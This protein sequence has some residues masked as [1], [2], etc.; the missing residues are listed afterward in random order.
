M[1]FIGKKRKDFQQYNVPRINEV[2]A[3]Y[4]SGSDG[5]VPEVNVAVFPKKG[6][7]IKILKSI[8]ENVDP[9][10]YPIFFP[11]GTMGWCPNLK[12]TCGKA[13]ISRAQYVSYRIARRD[14]N[15]AE[16]NPIHY[17]RK[18]FHQYLVDQAIRIEKDRICADKYNNV[19]KSMERRSL[20]NDNT[21]LGKKVFLPSSVTKTPRWQSE[22]YQD[23]M[24]M[25]ARLGK[26]D[27]FLTMTCN[28]TWKQIK[29]NIEHNQ[30]S[31]D[32]PDL[33]SRVFN[34]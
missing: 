20:E 8:D 34:I 26:P 14:N 27:L 6:T 3:I 17:G 5:E 13:N 2:A 22:Q 28:P 30:Q 10:C 33:V 4:V 32:A 9:L 21:P 31:N 12:Q 7:E 24:T 25:I 16:F 1:E 29:E 15:S 23:A 11:K 19:N 18:L